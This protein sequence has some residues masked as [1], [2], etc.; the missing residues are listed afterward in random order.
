MTMSD[1][2]GE[3]GDDTLDWFK[4]DH[5]S[6]ETAQ[7]VEAAFMPRTAWVRDSVHPDRERLG[8]RAG[9]WQAFLGASITPP[10]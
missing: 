8:F 5:S 1:E 3:S 2:Q 7:C 10:G 9:E 6:A 4:S